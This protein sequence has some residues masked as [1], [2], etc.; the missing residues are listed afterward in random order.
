MLSDAV[1]RLTGHLQARLL[2][3]SPGSWGYTLKLL[4]RA[5]CR[6]ELRRDLL[7][8]GGKRTGREETPLFCRWYLESPLPSLSLKC[9]ELCPYEVVFYSSLHPLC[10]AN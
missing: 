5:T 3:S 8:P 2:I 9:W 7:V 4:E 1:A 6:K 10:L